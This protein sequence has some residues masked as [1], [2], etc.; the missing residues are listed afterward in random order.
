MMVEVK[1]Y[2]KISIGYLILFLTCEH[3]SALI[4]SL[5]FYNMNYLFRTVI[6]ETLTLTLVSLYESSK[7]KL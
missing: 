3:L 2:N 7:D 5:L 6:G 4:N 1:G